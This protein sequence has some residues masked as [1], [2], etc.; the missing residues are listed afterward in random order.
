MSE[1]KYLDL[2]KEEDTR[3]DGTRNGH[4][5]DVAEGGDDKNNI[6]DLRW[7][8]YVKYNEDLIKGC[9]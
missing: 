7:E 2:S 6:H 4:W 9:F 3:M 1:E 5:R 8:L